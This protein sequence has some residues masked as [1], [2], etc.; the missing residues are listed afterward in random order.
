MCK[1][2]PQIRV[3]FCGRPGCVAPPQPRVGMGVFVVRQGKFLMGKRNGSHGA[4]TWSV[5]GGHQDFGESFE[6]TSQREVMEET[7]LV[8]ADVSLAGVTNDYHE[9]WQTHHVTLWMIGHCAT[10]DPQ[11]REPDKF[12]DQSWYDF[13]SL[14]E[15]LFFPWHQLMSSE[16]YTTVQ[17]TI[18]DSE[19]R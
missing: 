5:P 17:S 1:C 14:P 15:P 8:L 19:A 3:P 13:A 6:E 7:G 10:G 2:T 16:F 11:E 9:G 18:K 12:T 4:G